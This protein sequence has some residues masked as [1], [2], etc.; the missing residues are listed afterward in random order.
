VFSFHLRRLWLPATCKN[1]NRKSPPS[2]WNNI[3]WEPRS[4]PRIG[5]ERQEYRINFLDATSLMLGKAVA[6]TNRYDLDRT[7]LFLCV[8]FGRQLQGSQH[9]WRH[10]INSFASSNLFPDTTPSYLILRRVSMI[11]RFEAEYQTALKVRQSNEELDMAPTPL[12]VYNQFQHQLQPPGRQCAVSS[13][14]ARKFIRMFRREWRFGFRKFNVHDD[15]TSEERV[16]MMR[17]STCWPILVYQNYYFEWKCGPIFGSI[18]W[19]SFLTSL[20]RIL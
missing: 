5:R 1:G 15:T 12:E 13:H 4:S 8:K 9:D 16:L 10:L 17:L 14:R 11:S 7:T 3:N 6:L 19:P 18:F 20:L 2:R